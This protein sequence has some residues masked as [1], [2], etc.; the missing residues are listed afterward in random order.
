MFGLI[1][2]RK[3][4]VL[5][6]W[7]VPLKDFQSDTEQF[8]RA[9]EAELAARELPGLMPERILFRKGALWTANRTYLRLRRE[10]IVYD[11]CAASF[12]K[13]WW[14]SAR[15][16]ELPRSHGCL[17][18]IVLLLITA[19][20]SLVFLYLFGF[21]VGTL[22]LVSTASTL[23]LFFSLLGQWSDLD[24]FLM[25]VPILGSLYESFGRRNT[26]HRQDEWIMFADIANG[27]VKEKV[28]E[29]CAAG[30]VHDP[31]FIKIDSPEQV[32]TERELAK[33]MRPEP[34]RAP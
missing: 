13:C 4:I 3:P 34:S 21:F 18:L 16:A 17:S 26:Y 7:L 20:L 10:R 31:L 29:F 24:D 25:Q 22:V 19:H 28:I 8:Y 23:V 32:L 15:A 6:H 12:G 5:A 11:L 30:G 33:Y 14:F 1:R 9:I 2:K 27:I